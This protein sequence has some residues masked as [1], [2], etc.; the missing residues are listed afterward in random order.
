M[1]ERCS[2]NDVHQ[3][4]HCQT[5]TPIEPTIL[6]NLYRFCKKNRTYVSLELAQ[7][8]TIKRQDWI[9]RL[10]FDEGT[11][12]WFWEMISWQGK[13]YNRWGTVKTKGKIREI[14]LKTGFS[15]VRDHQGKFGYHPHTI[16]EYT[17][18][19]SKNPLN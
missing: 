19:Q 2:L 18:W 15:Y 7:K 13:F 1:V 8:L 3:V 16:T 6:Q 9:L 17:Q 5:T 14:D 12:Q 11:Y 4:L 10:E